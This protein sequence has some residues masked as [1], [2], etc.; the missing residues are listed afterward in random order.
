[1]LL[2]LCLKYLSRSLCLPFFYLTLSRY[3]LILPHGLFA[4]LKLVVDLQSF[5]S[6]DLLSIISILVV[7]CF[8][9]LN[10]GKWM[11]NVDPY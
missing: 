4:F 7:L 8:M 6:I 5:Y 10:V 1:M 11:I 9:L 3:L 2:L